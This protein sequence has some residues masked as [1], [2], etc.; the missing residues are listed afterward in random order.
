[1]TCKCPAIDGYVIRRKD[2]PHHP[3]RK[4][5]ATEPPAQVTTADI[6]AACAWADYREDFGVPANQ[7][8]AAHKAFMAGWAARTA[9]QSGALR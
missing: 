1:M 5:A 7:M 9:D 4:P 3:P 8:T 6:E 2:C